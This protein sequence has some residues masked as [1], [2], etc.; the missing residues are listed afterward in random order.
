MIRS[1]SL[2]VVMAPAQ[3]FVM[4]TAGTKGSALVLVNEPV[5]LGG[6]GVAGRQDKRLDSQED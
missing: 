2:F 6:S 3:E 1:L 5:H 4:K